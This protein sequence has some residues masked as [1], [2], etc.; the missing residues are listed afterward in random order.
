[1]KRNG[2]EVFL[3]VKIG[4]NVDILMTRYAV[5]EERNVDFR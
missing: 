4:K 3:T 2:E 5:E 1:M